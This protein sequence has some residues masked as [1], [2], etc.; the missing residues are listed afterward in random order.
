MSAKGLGGKVPS[1]QEII[2][3]IFNVHEPLRPAN[4]HK[5]K[6]QKVEL[7]VGLESE[8]VE[9]YSD[10][11]APVLTSS[12]SHPVMEQEI[13]QAKAEGQ[14]LMSQMRQILGLF[15]DEDSNELDAP[16]EACQHSL[17]SA[18]RDAERE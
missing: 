12:K 13:E 10:S 3:S 6:R 7:E 2:E 4:T 9:S 5:N 14:E 15:L 17:G 8:C 16:S 11:E 18:E 1:V